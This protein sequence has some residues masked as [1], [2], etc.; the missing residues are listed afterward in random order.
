[1]EAYFALKSRYA[2]NTQRR[3]ASHSHT[4][5]NTG[6]NKYILVKFSLVGHTTYL[7]HQHGRVWCVLR[8]VVQS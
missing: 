3:D 8:N 2:P 1:M 4:R 7:V 5:E 6:V